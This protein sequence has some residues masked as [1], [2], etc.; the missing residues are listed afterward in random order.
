M[1]GIL[2]LILWVKLS[3]G[4]PTLETRVF[5]TEMECRDATV[6]FVTEL[7]L[8]GNKYVITAGCFG[9][10]PAMEATK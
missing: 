5:K 6:K 1:T 4:Q 9:K 2:M 10:V 3:T 8:D 7:N